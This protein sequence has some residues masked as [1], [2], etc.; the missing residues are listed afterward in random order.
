M[1]WFLAPLFRLMK[2]HQPRGFFAKESVFKIHNSKDQNENNEFRNGKKSQRNFELI[3]DQ[4]PNRPSVLA[5]LSRLTD[6]RL[7]RGLSCG[8]TEAPALQSKT[9][10]RV[11]NEIKKRT[12]QTSGK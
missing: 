9:G 12:E 7:P 5:P 4:C 6:F 2:F 8:R 3:K 10:E 1:H 11:L